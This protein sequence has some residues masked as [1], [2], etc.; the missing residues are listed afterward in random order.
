MC[1]ANAD[2][3]RAKALA[4]LG[5][6][7]D[8]SRGQWFERGRLAYHVRR[9]LS[10]A[11]EAVVGPVVDCRGTEE[12]EKRFEALKA[13]LPSAARLMAWEEAADAR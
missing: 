1:R 9:R 13:V 7:G 4:A 11:E 12:W 6:V 2:V 3:Y 10:E 5:G 8:R